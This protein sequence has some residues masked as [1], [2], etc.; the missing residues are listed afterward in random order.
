MSKLINI[1]KSIFREKAKHLIYFVLIIGL[2]SV[3]I[4]IIDPIMSRNI[5]D[6][7]TS[8]SQVSI[9]GSYL[10]VFLML[11]ITFILV[12]V[13]NVYCDI[14]LYNA[15]GNGVAKVL[16]IYH[17]SKWDLK[18]KK[19]N[20]G[21]VFN[22]INSGVDATAYIWLFISLIILNF[23]SLF[24]LLYMGIKISYWV[25][26]FSTMLFIF[27]VIM[28]KYRTDKNIIF[29]NLSYDVTS[30]IEVQT[31]ELINE[32][33][34]LKIINKFDLA[35]EEYKQNRENFWKIEK[36]K[37]KMNLVFD[38][39]ERIVKELLYGGISLILLP[40]L[41]SSIIGVGQVAAAFALFN[42][43]YFNLNNLKR[44]ISN[45]PGCFVPMGKLHELIH[46][47]DNSITD[48]NNTNSLISIDSM[49][50]KVDDK[51]ILD[52]I[53]LD[54]NENE[55]VAV[56]GLNGSGKSTLLKAILG[57]NTDYSGKCY[58][59]NVDMRFSDYEQ[60]SSIFSYIPSRAQLYAKSSAWN[61]ESGSIDL[62]EEHRYKII[63][64][65][66]IDSPT[67]S[68]VEKLASELSG[69][70]AQRVNVARGVA[71][72]NKILIADE[73]TASLDSKAA[74]KVMKLLMEEYKTG[75]VVT[76]NMEH[77]NYFKRVIVIE[78]GRV[79]ADDV[80]S[81]IIQNKLLNNTS[82]S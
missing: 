22:R 31:H 38:T 62:K 17:N 60:K 68:F 70:Q 28:T 67:E 69:G 49:T 4:T 46:V 2:V 26:I 63:K 80:P 77:L 56:V 51:C 57:L 35:C 54:I 64:A 45:L 81:N 19:F 50:F 12:F 72:S 11:F 1:S 42:S 79:I 41:R 20:E 48:I 23:V 3:M 15:V 29:E 44:P 47:A 75:V 8:N 32:V 6:S 58:V 18:V 40:L 82:Y 76:H 43:F 13:Q 21:E 61:I 7:F 5:F 30:A 27:V 25:I 9:N 16:K 14:W 55:M 73:P 53:N 66:D 33:E 71:S 59:N 65:L 37:L 74:T 78:N 24:I 36:S 34:Y 52:N 39:L 10:L